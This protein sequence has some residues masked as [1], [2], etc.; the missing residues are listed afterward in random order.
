MLQKI[1]KAAYVSAYAVGAVLLVM[2]YI[3]GAGDAVRNAGIAAMIA[4]VV[5]HTVYNFKYKPRPS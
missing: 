2:R 5:I 4:G 3:A 1:L